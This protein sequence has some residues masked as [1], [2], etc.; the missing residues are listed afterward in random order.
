MND[1]RSI[2]RWALVHQLLAIKTEGREMALPWAS[3]QW[4]S[5]LDR[6]PER[7]HR[8]QQNMQDSDTLGISENTKSALMGFE[9]KYENESCSIIYLVTS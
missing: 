1:L 8:K 2:T 5:A 9:N 3:Q 6:T 4:A 7:V